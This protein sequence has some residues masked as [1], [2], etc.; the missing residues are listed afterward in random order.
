[1]K[2]PLEIAI[3]LIDSAVEIA[4]ADPEPLI[5]YWL[6]QLHA[7][8]RLPVANQVNEVIDRKR[9][10][11]RGDVALRPLE[12]FS[13]VDADDLFAGLM[14]NAPREENG[15]AHSMRNRLSSAFAPHEEN[16]LPHYFPQPWCS[17]LDAIPMSPAAVRV[18]LALSGEEVAALVRD[19]KHLLQHKARSVVRGPRSIGARAHDDQPSL[20]VAVAPFADTLSLPALLYAVSDQVGVALDFLPATFFKESPSD[21]QGAKYLG[22]VGNFD[23]GYCIKQDLQALQPKSMVHQIFDGGITRSILLRFNRDEA[24]FIERFPQVLHFSM[25]GELGPNKNNMFTLDASTTESAA[26]RISHSKKLSIPDD[27]V[28]SDVFHPNSN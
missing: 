27:L 10:L 25:L 18:A 6:N 24:S 28:A 12:S 22:G 26:L 16:F 19:I 17:A 13:Y 4:P 14:E 20:R 11:K 7:P 1:M 21:P 9:M 5:A 23:I 15:A 2:P 8:S 3:R